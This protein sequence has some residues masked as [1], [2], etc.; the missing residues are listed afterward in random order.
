MNKKIAIPVIIVAVVALS[1]FLLH[2]SNNKVDTVNPDSHTQEDLA[3]FCITKVQLHWASMWETKCVSKG[4]PDDCS[5]SQFDT[6][7]M[8]KIF[9]EETDYCNKTYGVVGG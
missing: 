6:N 7:E 3:L 4:L 9:D 8:S 2:F 1:F 5:L